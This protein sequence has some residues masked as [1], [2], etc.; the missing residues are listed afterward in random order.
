MRF[1]YANYWLLIWALMPDLINS[2]IY[3]LFI[4]EV[5][6]R[7]CQLEDFNSSHFRRSPVVSSNLLL[8]LTVQP[9]Q[10]ERHSGLLAFRTVLIPYTSLVY[11][12]CMI[13]PA[14]VSTKHTR[15]LFKLFL[16]VA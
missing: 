1:D 15:D 11:T 5:F 16:S 8:S 2:Q 12:S 4:F 3:F 9:E 10:L 14:A 6:E 7:P 13:Q